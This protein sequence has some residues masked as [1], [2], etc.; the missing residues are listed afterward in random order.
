MQ[1]CEVEQGY[2]PSFLSLAQFFSSTFVL[3]ATFMVTFSRFLLYMLKRVKL[4]VKYLF[5]LFDK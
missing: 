1:F 4:K 5:D 3:S 2:L